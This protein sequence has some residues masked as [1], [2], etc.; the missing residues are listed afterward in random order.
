MSTGLLRLLRGGL[1]ALGVVAVV[2]PS[3]AHHSFAMFDR[4][5]TVSLTGTV[6]TFTWTNPHTF[7]WVYVDN[8]HGGQDIWAIEFSSG[9]AALART[10]WTRET[11]KPGDKIVLEINPLKDGRT[12]GM[13]RRA[14][15]ADGR[16]LDEHID[17]AP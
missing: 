11:L 4:G 2:L 3:Q 13:L 9:P 14:Q 8:G 16:I 17:P 6:R 10:G 15:L 7:V 5:K 1:G 12:G